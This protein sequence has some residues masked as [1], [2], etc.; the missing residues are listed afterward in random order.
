MSV[1]LRWG[2]Y[3]WIP[4]LLMGGIIGTVILAIS[5]NVMGEEWHGYWYVPLLGYYVLL[6]ICQSHYFKVPWKG[7]NLYGLGRQ[8]VSISGAVFI[9]LVNGY[10]INDIVGISNPNIAMAGH[11]AFIVF[12]FFFYGWDDFF[13][14]G[15]L[16]RWMKIDALKAIFWYVF[17]WIFWYFVFAI[18]GGP[19]SALDKFQPAVLNMILGTFQWV[20]MM[21][22]MTAITWRE[23]IDSIKWPNDYVRGIVTLS[24]AIIAGMIIANISY[25]LVNGVKPELA[26][27][28]KWHHV[29][30]MGTYPL[31]P[32]ILF[33]LYSNHF[34]HIS[35]LKK[36]TV[37]RTAWLVIMVIV[38]YFIFRFAIA[39]S[40]IFGEHVWWHHFDLYFN[41]TVSIIPLTHHWFCQ[42]WGFVRVE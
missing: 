12:G 28:D 4:A 18:P 37:S 22:M 24:F 26:G 38:E 10:I 23:F 5:W 27:A 8:W 19:V 36:K 33:G 29:L 11:F 6:S 32:I 39:P 41:F 31:I 3:T 42:R 13:F 17:I 35:D 25:A 2:S 34:N 30:Y 40:G 20:I 9:Y 14:K 7:P 15:A 21:E 1:K 16:V